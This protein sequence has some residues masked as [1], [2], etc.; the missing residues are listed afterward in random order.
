[1]KQADPQCGK[2]GTKDKYTALFKVREVIDILDDFD[3][4]EDQDYL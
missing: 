2:S 1:M 3:E 4:E